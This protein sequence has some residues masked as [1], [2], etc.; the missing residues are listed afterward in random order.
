[1]HPRLVLARRYEL[2]ELLGE[3]GM[4]SVWRARQLSFDREVAVKLMNPYV[5]ASPEGVARF[6]REAQAIAGLNSEHVVQVFDFGIDEETGALFMVMELLRGKALDQYLSERV[7]LPPLEVLHVLEHVGRAMA[8]AHQSK[9]KVVHRDLKPSN[10]F[11]V[12][13]DGELPLFKVLDFGIA[14][15]DDLSSSGLATQTGTV[16]GTLFYMSPEQIRGGHVDHRSDLWAMAVIA[17]ECMTGMRPFRGVNQGEV[18]LRVCVEPIEPPSLWGPVPFGFDEWFFRGVQRDREQ[19]FQTAK[20]MLAELRLVLA[21]V[22]PVEDARNVASSTCAASTLNVLRPSEEVSS[23]TSTPSTQA[24][25]ERGAE[26]D[27]YDTN[28]PTISPAGV[29]RLTAVNYR[30]FVVVATFGIGVLS[31]FGWAINS[32]SEVP[33]EPEE[34]GA[35]PRLPVTQVV[36]TTS[37]MNLSTIPLTSESRSTFDDETALSVGVSHLSP[38]SEPSPE[39]TSFKEPTAIVA[40][41]ASVPRSVSDTH[42]LPRRPNSALSSRSPIAAPK[43]RLAI[44]RALLT[45]DSSASGHTVEP[46]GLSQTKTEPSAQPSPTTSPSTKR[47]SW[48]ELLKSR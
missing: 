16:I 42:P 20:E 48:D 6:K 44:S 47:H 27:T 45:H 14:K 35:T 11:L 1:M 28:G 9:R 5:A 36:A 38:Q 22:P 7:A 29:A 2:I 24:A 37:Q 23:A 12:P 30:P 3:G 18:T 41:A 33:G 10:I 13:R 34:L 31:L 32:F 26:P 8:C 15:M 4:G 25:P 40:K 43:T 46:T 17:F 39:G 19:R 21:G